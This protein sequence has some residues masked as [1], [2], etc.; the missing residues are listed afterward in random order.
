MNARLIWAILGVAGVG[1]A[2]VAALQRPLPAAA[3]TAYWT[4]R[5]TQGVRL[6]VHGF[7]ERDKPHPTGFGHYAYLL[8]ADRGERTRAQ[9]LAAAAAFFKLFE[10]VDR[11]A[12]SPGAPFGVPRDK[13]ALLLTPVATMGERR[14]QSAADMLDAYDYDAACATYR[15]IAQV[16]P[17]PMVALVASRYPIIPTKRLDDGSVFVTD[18]C[19][20]GKIEEKLRELEQRLTVD[21]ARL[22]ELRIVTQM[23]TVFAALGEFARRV[24]GNRCMDPPSDVCP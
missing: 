12:L 3:A 4:K 7:Q 2:G 23:N 5:Q 16:K 24:P 17:V 18:L 13:L 8:F 20:T 21:A 15:Q 1:A 10:D 14:L 11:I 19:T 22:P 6:L 9:R